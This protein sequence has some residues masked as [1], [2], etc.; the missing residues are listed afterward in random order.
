[1]PNTNQTLFIVIFSLIAAIIVLLTYVCWLKRMKM[2]AKR[3]ILHEQH[4][5]ER[6]QQQQLSD[7]Q[8]QHL[9]PVLLQQ[10]YDQDIQRQRHLNYHNEQVPQY[11]PHSSTNNLVNIHDESERDATI[12]HTEQPPIHTN[13]NQQNPFADNNRS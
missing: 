3:D 5:L 6:G 13:T 2:A 4:Q 1:M 7:T 10:L 8:L 12:I 11:T 9:K